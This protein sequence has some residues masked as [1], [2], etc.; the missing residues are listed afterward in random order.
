MPHSHVPERQ[1][2]TGRPP[3]PAHLPNLL[4][5]PWRG[6]WS[7]GRLGLGVGVGGGGQ[8]D[9]S[10]NIALQRPTHFLI[11][12]TKRRVPQTGFLLQGMSVCWGG[13]PPFHSFLPSPG[14]PTPPPSCSSPRHHAAEPSALSSSSSGGGGGGGV[15]RRRPPG[16][17]RPAARGPGPRRHGHRVTPPM[18]HKEDE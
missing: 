8:T 1:P 11:H 13:V 6:W 2:A 9:S 3:L 12:P 17:D 5:I 7:G 14:V 16:A 10:G 4:R 15:G 18:A